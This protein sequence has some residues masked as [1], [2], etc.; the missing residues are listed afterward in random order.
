MSPAAE[1]LARGLG[2]YVVLTWL[3]LRTM[4][5]ARTPFERILAFGITAT[6]SLQAAM[7]IAVA[8][9]AT[10][11]TGISLPLISAG[12]SGVMAFSLAIGV[13]TA[14]AARAEKLGPAPEHLVDRTEGSPGQL[15]RWE[16]AA[17]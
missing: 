10:P 14:I 3:G 2:L 13:L 6:I 1:S 17:W 16:A 8:T 15:A 5:T 12:G 9:V 4:W 11:T 7:N